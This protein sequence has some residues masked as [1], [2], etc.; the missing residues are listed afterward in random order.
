MQG[1]QGEARSVPIELYAWFTEGFDTADFK[2][3]KTLLD[4]LSRNASLGSLAGGS[5]LGLAQRRAHCGREL[6]HRK[7][8]PHDD[9]AGKLFA[10]PRMIDVA[11]DEHRPNLRTPDA[12]LFEQIDTRHAW[13]R[14]IDDQQIDRGI[15]VQCGERSVAI[16]GLDHVV[17]P[18]AQQHRGNFAH[19]TVIVNQ[20][21][22][23]RAHSISC[24]GHHRSP[25]CK[26]AE[27]RYICRQD[28]TEFCQP[29]E[30]M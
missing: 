10:Q 8:L 9:F 1:R 15:G 11:G 13:H 27:L 19:V 3:A 20:Q 4:Q 23:S 5:A 2:A 26:R 12:G 30:C 21:D 28:V 16:G 17:S 7:R 25:R 6:I 24:R 29:L 18:I 22:V 14:K